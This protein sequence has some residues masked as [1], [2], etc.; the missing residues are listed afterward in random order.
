VKIQDLTQNLTAIS[1]LYSK[2]FSIERTPEWYLIKIQE[3]LGELAS[4]YLK[5]TGRARTEGVTVNDL[6][7]NFE[8]EIADVLAM[9]M[10]F[11][12]SQDVD[13]EKALRE[14]WYKHLEGTRSKNEN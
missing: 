7:K 9:T 14:K 5:L 3:E 10:L 4:A 8:E 1:D 11:A 13:I 6:K 2:R 12:K